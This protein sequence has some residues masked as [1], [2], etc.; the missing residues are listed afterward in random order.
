[1]ETKKCNICNYTLDKNNNCINCLE[2]IIL[3][4]MDY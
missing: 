4:Q 1:M 2:F 3:D